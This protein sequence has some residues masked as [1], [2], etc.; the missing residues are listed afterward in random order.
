MADLLECLLQI[1]GLQET[2]GRIAGLVSTVDAARWAEPPAGGGT[3]SASQLLAR[4]A[5]IESLHAGSLRAML[6]LPAPALPRLEPAAAAGDAQQDTR[7]PAQAL[8]RFLANRRENLDIL[9]RCSAEDLS[10]TGPGPNGRAISVADLVAFML[11]NDVETT[12]E[13][14]RVLGYV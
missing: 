9:D 12:G 14:R 11:A 2:A 5:E 3:I 7:P 10:R 1:K 8:E 4:L 6:A 13:I